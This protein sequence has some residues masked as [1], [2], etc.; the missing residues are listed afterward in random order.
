MVHFNCRVTNDMVVSTRRFP[1]ISQNRHYL[2]YS[3]KVFTKKTA[4]PF[5]GFNLIQNSSDYELFLKYICGFNFIFH[6]NVYITNYNAQGI[7][8]QKDSINTIIKEIK[9]I[10]HY[11]LCRISPLTLIQLYFK[12]FLY[13]LPGS[14]LIINAIRKTILKQR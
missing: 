1:K 4:I 3:I 7:S 13:L 6:D 2:V 14:N 12:K 5:S 8:A 9:L 11:H 10:Q